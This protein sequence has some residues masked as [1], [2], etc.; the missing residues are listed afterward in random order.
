MKMV[1]DQ[2][3]DALAIIVK[4]SESDEPKEG[5]IIDCGGR[6][7]IVSL[8]ILDTPLRVS[9]PLGIDLNIEGV[10]GKRAECG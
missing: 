3:K 10:A 1:Y 5:V 4:N 8:E 9:E 7:D 6:G 2:G